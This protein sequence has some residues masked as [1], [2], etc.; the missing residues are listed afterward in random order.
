M[1]AED[2]AGIRQLLKAEL[3]KD[4]HDI[5]E[6]KDG[7][8][9]LALVSEIKPNLIIADQKMPNMTG[10]RLFESVRNLGLDYQ[11]IPFLFLSASNDESTKIERL[12]G[13]ADGVFTKPLNFQLLRAH[14]NA[15]LANS[16]RHSEFFEQKLEAISNL[17]LTDNKYS[18][19]HFAPL[20]D[21]V[22]QYLGSIRTS[23]ETMQAVNELASAQQPQQANAAAFI[24]HETSNQPLS[25]VRFC[26]GQINRRRDLVASINSESLTWWLIF[27]VAEAQFAGESL[28]VSDLYFSTPSAKTTI[29]SRINMLVEKDILMK[30]DHP[31]DGRRQHLKLTPNFQNTFDQHI[32]DSIHVLEGFLPFTQSLK[33]P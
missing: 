5:S 15:C 11:I 20:G 16:R 4:G 32:L 26:L 17:I 18:F 31:S 12:N 9:G 23:I 10:D 21:N 33:L 29:N 24:H 7:I 3:E 27:T 28:F 1:V 30:H 6:A 13:G 19:D 14:V 22:D 2:D 25:Y 8:Q